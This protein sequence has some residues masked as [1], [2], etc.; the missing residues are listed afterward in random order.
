MRQLRDDIDLAEEP[1]PHQQGREIWIE[2]FDGD[3]PPRVTLFCQVDR[4]H[5]SATDLLQDLVP[6]GEG[7]A[8]ASQQVIAHRQFN[9]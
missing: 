9:P 2:Y 1:L 4:R 5:P 6:V 7:G 3:S 8:E